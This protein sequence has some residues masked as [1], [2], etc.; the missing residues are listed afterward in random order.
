MSLEG[1]SRS[2]HIRR[3]EEEF[4]ALELEGGRSR[5]EKEK[6]RENREG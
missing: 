4:G 6:R 1:Y 5:K 3:E 2:Q